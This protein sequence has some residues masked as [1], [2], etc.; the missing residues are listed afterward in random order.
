[1][2]RWFYSLDNRQQWGPVTAE[3]LRHLARSGVLRPECMVIP[4][5]GGNWL[6]AGSV[7]GLFPESLQPAVPLAPDE[8]LAANEP[9]VRPRR[10]GLR[11]LVFASLLLLVL[12]ALG[13]GTL[14]FFLRRTSRLAPFASLVPEDAVLAL[15]VNLAEQEQ[16]AGVK[17]EAAALQKALRASHKDL[18]LEPGTARLTTLFAAVT[19]NGQGVLAW[20]FDQQVRV[21]NCLK[22]RYREVEKDGTTYWTDRFGQGTTWCVDSQGRL[23][24]GPFDLVEGAVA[25]AKARKKTQAYDDLARWVGDVPA[26]AFLWGTVD[27]ARVESGRLPLPPRQ[28]DALKGTRISGLFFSLDYAEDR[29]LAFRTTVTCPTASDARTC[30]EVLDDMRQEVGKFLQ[31][32]LGDVQARWAAKAMASS[33]LRDSGKNLLIDVDLPLAVMRLGLEAQTKALLLAQDR[34]QAETRRS[35]EAKVRRGDG[36]LRDERF[37]EAEAAYVEALELIPGDGAAQAKLNQAKAAGERQKRFDEA[38]A[39]A[40]QALAAGD[41]DQAAV[42]LDLARDLRPHDPRLRDLAARRQALVRDQA[43]EKAWREGNAALAVVDL[44]RARSHFQTAA[45]IRPKDGAVQES[46]AVL[47]KVQDA[48]AFLADAGNALAGG[49]TAGA[50]EAINKTRDLILADLK[51]ADERFRPVVDKLAGETMQ[52]L[53]SQVR[54]C[55]DASAARKEKGVLAGRNKDYATAVREFDQGLRELNQARTCLKGFEV[56]AGREQVEKKR[57]E[58][59]ADLAALGLE[60]RKGRGQVCMQQ[61]GD[62]IAGAHKDLALA[63]RDAPRLLA[64]RQKLRDALKALEEAKDLPGT[65]PDPVIEQTGKTLADV[66]KLIQPIDLDFKERRV[67]AGWSFNQARWLFGNDGT[68]TWLQSAD[69]AST[70]LVSPAVEFPV[71]FELA[72]DFSL[73]S[74]TGKVA[75]GS[76]RT[77]EDLLVITLLAKEQGAP[78]LVIHLGKEPGS[79]PPYNTSRIL[80]GKHSHHLGHL[81]D[82]RDPVSRLRLRRHKGRANLLVNGEAL[83]SFL[84]GSAFKQVAI[85]V[86][87]GLD[88]RQEIAASPILY[89]IGLKLHVQ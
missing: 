88:A 13:A 69:R 31:R 43:F 71:D 53:W 59:D 55:R 75:N 26:N 15:V 77:F 78:A 82:R 48:K 63:R 45:R 67:A 14:F 23:L 81:A 41:A 89:Q 46:L 50:S 58:I 54:A 65:A 12:A 25:R 18:H 38:I 10:S 7:K 84:E 66:A 33:R 87:N 28:A 56:L 36:A 60:Q 4:E 51:K 74:R 86:N 52:V 61:A 32:G 16:T 37:P 85:T 73:L 21:G 83:A 35:F 24:S 11:K 29:D 47:Q 42:K 62:L 6:P 19:K 44:E 57:Q 68:R 76:W 2:S 72:V 8:A 17:E 5:G 9:P 49:N 1:M 20:V 22:G 27:F 70:R 80:V 30:R 3:Q 39:E 40:N 79:R 34:L 64:A